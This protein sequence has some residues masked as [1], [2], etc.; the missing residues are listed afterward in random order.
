MDLHKNAHDL[1]F[2]AAQTQQ[3][4]AQKKREKE[5]EKD[6]ALKKQQRELAKQ[7]KKPFYLKKCKFV[8][9]QKE[10]LA[11]SDQQSSPTS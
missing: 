9:K 4:N 8:R 11:G 3:E 7:G 1:P 5:R 2:F 10:G 6:L